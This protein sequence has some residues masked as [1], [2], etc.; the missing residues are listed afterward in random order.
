MGGTLSPRTSKNYGPF[1]GALNNRCLIIIGTQ[2]GT[3]IS[4]TTQILARLFARAGAGFLGLCSRFLGPFVGLYIAGASADHLGPGWTAA[5]AA[6]VQL[7]QGM[8]SNSS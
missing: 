7:V 4:S 1:L 6:T 3:L 5:V 2:K 8:C